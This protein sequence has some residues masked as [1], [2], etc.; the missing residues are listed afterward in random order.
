MKLISTLA[1][2]GLILSHASCTKKTN[3]G[4]DPRV[5]TLGTVE[6]TARLVE[7]PEGAIFHRDLYDYATV[8]KYEVVAVHRGDVAKG[9]TIYVGHYDPWK[10]R[11]E[12][13]DK[14]AQNIGGDLRQFRAGDLHRM[15][16]EVPMD[17]HFMGGIVDKYF[18]KHGAPVYWA[19]W[20]N[21][22]D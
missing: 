19:V 21:A 5:Q 17:D 8:L 9:A 22:A 11:S 4:V 1:V 20:T 12:A 15:A 16:L 13:A 18:G 3:A 10:S 2:A 14:R 7:V 6:V